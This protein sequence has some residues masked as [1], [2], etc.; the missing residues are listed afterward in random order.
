[1]GWNDLPQYVGPGSMDGYAV[2]YGDDNARS[3]LGMMLAAAVDKTDRWDERLAKC[4]LANLRISGQFGF[5]PSRVDEGPLVQ[6]GWQHYFK[7]KNI[8][9][10]QNYQAKLLACSPLGLLANEVPF[11]PEL[12][13]D[14]PRHVHGRLFQARGIE[15]QHPDGSGKNASA[16]GLVGAGGRH[17]GTPP[18]V[19]QDYEDLLVGQDP[20]GAIREE[21]FAAGLGG[22]PLVGSNE[23][24]GTA[25]SPLI[26]ANGD[27]ACD[28]LYTT[29]FAFLG[30]HEAAAATGEPFYRQA[31][32][33]LAKFFC[34]VQVRSESHP[35]LDGGWF[36]GFDFKHWDYWASNADTG[37]GVWC[38]ETGSSQSWITAVL[39]FRQAEHVTLG[40]DGTEQDQ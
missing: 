34:R 10:E 23:A 15:P 12:R 17:S 7:G 6:N 30:L 13:K 32:E 8:N 29:N 38:L 22:L 9:Y 37:W 14:G 5:Q 16:V 27:P 2:Y 26:H 28:L 31:E 39:A 21:D 18:V 4:L 25:E 24:Y 36:R 35:E 19:G 3:M 40:L 1:M 33:K 20:C 11:V